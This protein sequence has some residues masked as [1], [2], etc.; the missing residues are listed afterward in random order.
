VDALYSKSTYHTRGWDLV[1]LIRKVTVRASGE[2][3][4]IDPY[5]RKL[6][7][8]ALDPPYDDNR[9]PTYDSP[10]GRLQFANVEIDL[11]ARRVWRDGVPVHDLTT[12]EFNVLQLLVEA[13]GNVV[14][15]HLL[16]RA[17]GTASDLTSVVTLHPCVSRLRKKLNDDDKDLI[18]TARGVGYSIYSA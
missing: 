2:P 12:A 1:D 7:G 3:S 10:R 8:P 13:R 9:G 15:Y 5:F 18:R 14:P 11:G 4:I 16:V 6:Y 17:T